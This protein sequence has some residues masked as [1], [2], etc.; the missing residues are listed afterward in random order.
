MNSIQNNNYLR[1]VSWSLQQIMRFAVSGSSYP[2]PWRGVEGEVKQC[3]K[4]FLLLTIN[5][6]IPQYL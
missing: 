5:K 6:N 2:F 3:L 1:K 4:S